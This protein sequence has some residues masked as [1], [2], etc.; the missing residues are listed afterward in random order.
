MKKMLAIVLCLVIVSSFFSGCNSA[1][2]LP[3]PGEFQVGYARV[4]IS[5]DYDVPYASNTYSTHVEERLYATCIAFREGSNTILLFHNDL[6]GSYIDPIGPARKDIEKATGIPVDNIMVNATHVHRA[7]RTGPTYVDMRNVTRYHEDLRA[8]MVEAAVAA[9]ADIKPATAYTASIETEGLNFVR[10]YNMEDGT[11]AGDNFGNAK[12]GYASHVS[13]PDRELTLVKFAREGCK[14]IILV[15]FATHPHHARGT[16]LTSDI[17]GVMREK[18]EKEMDCSFAWFTGAAGNV[19]P[20]SK[21]TSENAETTY[22]GKGEALA[23][24]AKK[25]AKNFTP[26]D[27]GRVQII[28][29][30]F[31]AKPKE[32][33]GYA[34]EIYMYTF[35]IGDIAF[36]SAPYEMFSENGK[37]IKENSPFDVTFICTLGF[38]AVGYIPS[39]DAYEYEGVGLSYEANAGYYARGTGED[40]AEKY[41]EMLQQ[42]HKTK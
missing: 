38:Y 28:K 9:L 33:G 5:P 40:L 21:I 26:V 16:F 42:L 22:E 29:H 10:H 30:I 37:Y 2:K 15:N 8:W 24:Y 12:A 6:I 39:N 1:E 27:T 34:P 7:P 19:N 36:V 25:A 13:E 20:H 18:M 41:L 32:E 14:D 4:D 17:V 35:S 11:V 23:D 3:E 31:E